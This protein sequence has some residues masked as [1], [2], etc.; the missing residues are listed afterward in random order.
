MTA[1]RIP[2]ST[3]YVTTSSM[4]IPMNEASQE[5]VLYINNRNYNYRGNPM[6]NYYHPGLRNHEIFSYVN[7]KNVLQPPLG[8]DSQPSEKKMSLEDAMIPLL[9][10]PKQGL[11]SLIHGWITLRLIVAIWEPL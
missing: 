11:K 5:Q 8:F 2:Q 3:E 9:R 1:Q 4:T 6:P 7:T 10:R